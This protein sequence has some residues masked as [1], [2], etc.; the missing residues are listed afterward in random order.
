MGSFFCEKGPL[1]ITFLVFTLGTTFGESI[2]VLIGV[3]PTFHG[4]C[5]QRFAGRTTMGVSHDHK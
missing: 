5:F 4:K 2:T 3:P 1:L